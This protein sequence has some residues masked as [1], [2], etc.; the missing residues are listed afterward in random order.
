MPSNAYTTTS[1]T[2]KTFPNFPRNPIPLN[3]IGVR[4][5]VGK[6]LFLVVSE[7][8]REGEEEEGA[9]EKDIVV[10]GQG[11]KDLDKVLLQ[12]DF[13]LLEDV[14]GEGVANETEG[15]EAGHE[16]RFHDVLER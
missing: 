1:I 4:T 16:E 13:S 12:F 14:D 15:G 2:T 8:L 7:Q 9:D 10:C 11:A 3:I 5:C 6:D